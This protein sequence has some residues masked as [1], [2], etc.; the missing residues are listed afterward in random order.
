ME[1]HTGEP[2][3]SG[4]D[5]L[6]QMRKIVEI[7]GIPPVDLISRAEPVCRDQHFELREDETWW[8]QS[9]HKPHSAR[10]VHPRAH[11]VY[12]T[13]KSCV[14]TS[15]MSILHIMTPS[16]Q[17]RSIAEIAGLNI[18]GPGGRR[19]NE[20]GHCVRNYELFLD[21]IERMLEYWCVRPALLISHYLRVIPQSCA[22]YCITAQKY[23]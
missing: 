12:C 11:L 7:L 20:A 19:R 5:K 13:L 4:A 9:R 1:M 6:D 23:E 21:F 18:G 16:W 2:L 14:A 17:S 8:L 15:L 22:F 10:H 3:F